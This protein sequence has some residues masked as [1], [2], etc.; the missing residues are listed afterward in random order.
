[1]LIV[2]SLGGHWSAGVEISADRSTYSNE[3]LAFKGGPAIEFDVFPYD[4]ST[5]KLLR[6]LYR[7]TANYF[8]YSDTTIFERVRETR[9]QQALVVGL[10]ATQP[11]GTAFEDRSEE[12]TSDLQSRG[13]LVCRLLLEKKKFMTIR[14][15]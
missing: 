11:W 5:R 4:Q 10:S 13:L 12:H 8:K 2:R 15:G 1:A 14:R 6:F 9:P 7:V 3:D